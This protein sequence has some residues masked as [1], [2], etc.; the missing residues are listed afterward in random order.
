MADKPRRVLIS[1]ALGGLGAALTR[2]FLQAGD[3]VF[4]LHR[5]TSPADELARAANVQFHRVDLSD[6]RAVANIPSTFL[7]IDILINNASEQPDIEITHKR[8]L[9]D[10]DRQWQ[11][12]A[13]AAIALTQLCTPALLR[14]RGLVINIL[15]SYTLETPPK[16]IAPYIVQ[17]YALLGFGL[18]LRE[19]LAGRGV[20][21]VQ[22]SPRV[23]DTA[24]LQKLPD[25]VREHLLAQMDT[26]SP[27]YVASKILDISH[28]GP[29]LAQNQL[30]D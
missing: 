10:F 30:I 7:D 16:G 25:Q 3:H 29:N 12:G 4:G 1:G 15:S 11:C 6:D 14:R 5:R 17:K 2:T 18:A 22:L 19:E 8:S 9:G 21:V 23:I 28:E 24:F 20:R 27:A 26:L 13:R